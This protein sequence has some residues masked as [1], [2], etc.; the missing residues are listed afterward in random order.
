MQVEMFTMKRIK[1]NLHMGL[2]IFIHT[3]KTQFNQIFYEQNTKC[4]NFFLKN[5]QFCALSFMCLYYSYHLI[6]DQVG[7]TEWDLSSREF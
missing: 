4:T 1:K 3:Q 2:Q 5:V 6:H 7:I